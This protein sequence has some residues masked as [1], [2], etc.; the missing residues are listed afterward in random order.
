MAMALPGSLDEVLVVNG[1]T[2]HLLR[3]VQRRPNQFLF[4]RIDRSHA[5][6]ALLR[7]KLAEAE[8]NLI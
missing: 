6:L 3:P 1:T 2:C 4:A 7:F 5:N 8:R